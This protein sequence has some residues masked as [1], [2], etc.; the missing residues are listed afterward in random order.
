MLGIERKH[1][2]IEITHKGEVVFFHQIQN[3]F[4]S[5]V[6][7]RSSRLREWTCTGATQL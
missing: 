4:G 5:G 1:F 3:V 6:E 2:E 7:E